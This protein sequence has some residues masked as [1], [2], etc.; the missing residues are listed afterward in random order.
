MKSRLVRLAD[1]RILERI[2]IESLK[3]TRRAIR[4]ARGGVGRSL[5]HYLLPVIHLPING[6]PEKRLRQKSYIPTGALECLTPAES[7]WTFI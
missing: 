7:T 3:D 6:V 5:R 4:G 1:L 2:D